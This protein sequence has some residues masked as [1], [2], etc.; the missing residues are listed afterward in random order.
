ME[1]VC[2]NSELEGIWG[3]Q[4]S[5][6]LVIGGYTI[7]RDEVQALLKKAQ[8]IKSKYGLDPHCPVK[9]N[10]RDLDKALA[11]HGLSGQKD[12]LL[13][14]SNPLRTDLLNAL[15]AGGA[16]IFISAIHAYSNKKQVLGKTKEDLVSYSFGNLLMRA[17]LFCKETAGGRRVDTLLD[18][19]EGNRRTP[20][21][22]EYHT[23]WRYG[24]SGP[25][26]TGVKYQC[27]PL[28]DLAFAPG[29]VFGGMDFEPRLQFADLVVGAAREF[30]N[31]ALGKAKE[32]AFG[33]QRFK[34][35]VPHLYQTPK[36]QI[37]GKGM[38]VSPTKA[39][40]STAVL[41]GL[42]TLQGKN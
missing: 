24:R 41:A 25:E 39:E 40:L 42:K 30:I 4:A 6:V 15:A 9:W 21:A 18:W 32:D 34:S 3:A 22:A 38:T 29:S 1:L 20:F 23:G 19:P 31:F 7:P 35:L 28:A 17:G 27:G 33:V 26:D 2:D 10:V 16:T 12:V 11:A 37:L 14:Q 13:A 8:E 5:D 36:G